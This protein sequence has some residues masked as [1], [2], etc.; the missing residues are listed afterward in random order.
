MTATDFKNYL[1]TKLR[2]DVDFL[3]ALISAIKTCRPE[4]WTQYTSEV[5][6]EI[7]G[8]K[9]AALEGAREALDAVTNNLFA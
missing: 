9:E 2:A 8:T 3:E 7:P 5:G 4:M 1:L 6:M